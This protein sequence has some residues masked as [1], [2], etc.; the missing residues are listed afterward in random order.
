MNAGIA[1]YLIQQGVTNGAIY[2]LIALALV[3]V[4]SVT[5]VI[6]VQAGEFVS[7]GALTLY[8]LQQGRVPELAWFTALACLA[9]GLRDFTRFMRERR[10][11]RAGAGLWWSW[12]ACAAL[13]PLLDVL[14][15]HDGANAAV[16][17]ACA[18]LT[19]V[20]LAPAM[21]R[22]VY[23]PVARSSV[24]VLLI[25][26]VACHFV[27][28]GVAL[29][30]FGADGART[31]KWVH[32]D[33]Q[34]FG[35]SISYERMSVIAIA[36]AL[37][38]A[39]Y[40]FTRWTLRGRALRAAASNRRGSAI[41]GI[42]TDE[43]GTTA[44]AIMG[45]ICAAAGI[46][47]SPFVTIYFDSGFTL[48][49]KAFIGATVGALS[50][51]PL[52][53]AGALGLGIFES[54]IAFWSSA[55]QQAWVFAVMVPI[56]LLCSL[57][58]T[59][60]LDDEDEKELPP[61][62]HETFVGRAA[63]RLL[64]RL[65]RGLWIALGLAAVACVPLLAG[66][67]YTNLVCYVFVAILVNYGII[68]LTGI[69]G[70]VSLGQAAFVGIGAYAGAF[71]SLH[72]GLP[73]WEALPIVLG[74]T[75]VSAWIL[76]GITLRMRGHY[77]PIA[78]IAWS[79]SIFYVFAN[80]DALGASSGL[81]GIPPLALP[82][83]A[84]LGYKP[85][86]F[87]AMLLTC[88]GGHVLAANLLGS[89]Y[90]LA[91]RAL[92]SRESMAE[93]MG[94]NTS[95]MKT[96]VFMLAALYAAVA[97][98][99]YAHL[100]GFISPASFDL[101]SSVRYVFMCVIG[102]VGQ[103]AGAPLGAGLVELFNNWLQDHLTYGVFTRM[104]SVENVVFGVAVVLLLQ[105]TQH[106]VGYWLGALFPL[107]KPTASAPAPGPE[108]AADASG[109]PGPARTLR[110][111]GLTKRFEGMTAVADVNLDVRPHEIV[112]LIGPNGAGKSTI[113]HMISGL[114][115]PTAGTVSLG[116]ER[117]DGKAPH[118]VARRG[119]LRSFQHVKILAD[120]SVL[121][122]V[123]LGA[124][125]EQSPSLLRSLFLRRGHD[126]QLASRKAWRALERTG[127]ADWASAR[128]GTLA[129]GKQRILEI[130][131]AIAAEP[132]ILLLDEPAAGLRSAEKR[133]LASLL[134]A[135]RSEGVGILLVEHD[136]DFVMN[137]ADRVVVQNFGLTLASGSPAEVRQHPGV[138]AAYL[139]ECA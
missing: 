34:L 89:R 17:M 121:E 47:M 9:A 18:L 139:G 45:L 24:L 27:L 96:A 125:R 35:Q 72:Y 59:Q 40:T 41:V 112:A 22:L 14:A 91:L 10:A 25:V 78:T 130:A 3:L 138:V 32:G 44:F 33:V 126:D 11:G 16:L 116:E 88:I 98:W 90:G 52:A 62:A 101:A 99:F 65:P 100:Q 113:F 128:A 114:L 68:L 132:A 127:L 43:A 75:G 4:F 54:L 79:T 129:L 103:I 76:G 13:V 5:R 83:A 23:Q 64:G 120:R 36:L 77:L 136:M 86:L 122:N 15:V 124:H 109:V 57:R 58:S 117:L 48:S 73:G 123:L 28:N 135:L 49:L 60:F 118:E 6:L 87:Y 63:G 133:E 104:G 1:I 67:F 53:A 110:V 137:L 70:Q 84:Q 61:Q 56:L 66:D 131:R 46:L 71:A 93:S 50:S 2:C 51:F 102:G 42:G 107:R 31:L 29:M 119:L 12:F 74:V 81:G 80:S 21:Y 105:R 19:V 111:R 115:R 82:W 94:V 97:G 30:V 106:G 8:V 55:Y 85:A 134:D 37:M 20:P 26:S 69:A 108:M 95:R 92:R 7:F 38:G 39:L